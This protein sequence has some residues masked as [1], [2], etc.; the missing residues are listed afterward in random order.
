M[1]FEKKG[2]DKEQDNDCCPI[3]RPESDKCVLKKAS[4]ISGE[5]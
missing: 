4:V 2:S 1:N 5:R 3:Y